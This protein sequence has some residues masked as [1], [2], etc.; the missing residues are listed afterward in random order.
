MWP[1]TVILCWASPSSTKCVICNFIFDYLYWLAWRVILRFCCNFLKVSRSFTIDWNIIKLSIV[2][3]YYLHAPRVIYSIHNT[4]KKNLSLC[5]AFLRESTRIRTMLSAWLLV[6]GQ[7][8][9][10]QNFRGVVT[11]SRE[12]LFTLTTERWWQKLSGKQLKND[13]SCMSF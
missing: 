6:T 9:D 12:S 8:T 4:T 2:F 5:F 3:A 1:L 10:L 7:W 13:E 11:V